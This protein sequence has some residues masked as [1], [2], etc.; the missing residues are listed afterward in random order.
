MTASISTEE[1]VGF[2]PDQVHRLLSYLQTLH[3]Q[4]RVICC[5]KRFHR[6]HFMG[7]GRQFNPDQAHHVELL[8]NTR[9]SS[10]FKM[11]R[12]SSAFATPACGT[13]AA[14]MIAK[15]APLARRASAQSSLIESSGLAMALLYS[16]KVALL[17]LCSDVV[18]L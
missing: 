6:F 12:G 13:P 14:N 5:Q 15:Q 11:I 10:R 7:S 8:A 16:P 3:F 17:M 18:S 9:L 1:V 4:F 2:H